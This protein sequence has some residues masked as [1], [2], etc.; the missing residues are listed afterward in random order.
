MRGDILRR[1]LRRSWISTASW[2]ITLTSG[3]REIVKTEGIVW[4]KTCMWDIA[5]KT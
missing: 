4:K 5:E 3:E 1:A 2:I